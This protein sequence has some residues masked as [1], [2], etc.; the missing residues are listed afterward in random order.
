MVDCVDAKSLHCGHKKLLVSYVFS[1]AWTRVLILKFALSSVL[2]KKT[3]KTL[4]GFP[5][6]YF[7]SLSAEK[8]LDDAEVERSRGSVSL[9]FR[10][11]SSLVYSLAFML[12]C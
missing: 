4:M 7:F 5:L 9:L 10:F 6:R 12:S 3:W 2:D 8:G 1:D 11:A